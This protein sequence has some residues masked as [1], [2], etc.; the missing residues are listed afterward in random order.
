[1]PTIK[2]R[3]GTAAEWTSE[4]P[5]L[6][7]GELGYE[8][9]TGKYKIGNGTHYWSTR[10][11]YPTDPE[12]DIKLDEHEIATNPHS[13]YLQAAVVAQDTPPAD[14]GV[15]WLDT[16]AEEFVAASEI[17]AS[18][19]S[20]GAAD[21]VTLEQSQITG[22]TAALLA[23]APLSSPALTG[24]P[25][26]PTPAAGDNDTSIAT[27]AWAAERA[28]VGNRLTAN[29]ASGAEDGTTSGPY[30]GGATTRASVAD[31]VLQGTKSLRWQSTV[32][33][34]NFLGG[35]ITNGAAVTPGATYTYTVSVYR[36]PG[37]PQ[38]AVFGV[39][40]RDA[41][42]A[43]ISTTRE[44]GQ[45]LP[46]LVDSSWVT[47]TG[48]VVAP[49]GAA[50]ASLYFY[51]SSA[52]DV[53]YDRIGLWAGAG[54]DWAM[55]GV[56]ITNLGH[57]VTRPNIDDRLVEMWNPNKAGG[58]G[59]SVVDYDSGWRDIAS[60]I[61]P[62]FTS[63]AGK[64]LVRRQGDEVTVELRGIARATG[65]G[66]TANL[67]A[68]KVVALPDGFRSDTYTPVGV[69]SLEGVAGL[70]STGADPASLSIAVAGLTWSAGWATWGL[71]KFPTRQAIPTNL[72][73]TLVSAAPA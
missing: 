6:A 23:L 18:R 68:S 48:S 27:T 56:P 33:A 36:I 63:A 2:F 60:A 20:A 22:L 9:D 30:A 46:T 41:A 42:G 49:A 24:N 47:I 32:Q 72:P 37:S 38:P 21:P 43:N 19:H 17:H 55:P 5:I 12:M 62:D 71:A 7:E 1:M 67:S 16:D 10:P 40:W 66:S 35:H 51:Y 4:N 39:N 15:V 53:R 61:D 45:P 73:G 25:T 59:W 11:Y 14:T 3:R 69:C 44:T 28:T 8:T 58:A 65:S 26:A 52:F 70:L 50:Y 31:F 57:R 13:Q 54:G 64:V 34:E 29:V